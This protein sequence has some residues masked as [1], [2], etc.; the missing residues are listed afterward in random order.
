MDGNRTP[1]DS[2]YVGDEACR[3][4]VPEINGCWEEIP[5][6]ACI[7]GVILLTM[8]VCDAVISKCTQANLDKY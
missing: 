6:I 2:W 1:S 7:D 3:I 4:S 8:R 5:L